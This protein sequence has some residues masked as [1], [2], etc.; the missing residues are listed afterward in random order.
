MTRWKIDAVVERRLLALAGRRVAPF[1]GALGQADEIGDRVGR[2]LVEQP[3][4]EVAFRGIE[5]RVSS[6]L[7]VISFAR[8]DYPVNDVRRSP[9]AP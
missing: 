5:L 7:H 1:L 3:D 4:R 8:C 6:W 9:T 2:L